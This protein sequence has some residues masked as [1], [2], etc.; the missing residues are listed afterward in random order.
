VV[1]CLEKSTE[2]QPINLPGLGVLQEITLLIPA[3]ES[4]SMGG[5]SNGK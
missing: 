3:L 1:N 4:E 2:G 5:R